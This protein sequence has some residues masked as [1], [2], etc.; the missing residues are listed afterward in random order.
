MAHRA[1]FIVGFALM[2]AGSAINLVTDSIFIAFRRAGVNA[3]VD[4]G[5]GGTIKL[6]LIPV[7]AGSGV[8]GL[9]I[10]SVG[11]FAAAAV[12]SVILIWSMLH[13][14]PRLRESVAVMRPLLRFSAANYLAGVFAL[15]PSLVV[16]L[17]VLARLGASDAAYYYVAY[18]LANL[19]F[20]A[21]Y[22][23]CQ[24]FLAEGG[25]EEEDLKVLTRPRRRILAALTVPACLVVIV[26]APALLELFGA[27][28]SSHGTGFLILMALAAIPVAALNWL[29]NILRLLRQLVS[30]AVCNGAYAVAVC[31]LAWVLAPRGL[32]F[33]GVAWL[34]GSLV[35]VAVAA[36]GVRIGPGMESRG[37]D[38]PHREGSRPTT[39]R[40]SR[41]GRRVGARRGNKPPSAM[42]RGRAA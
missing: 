21:G 8:Y 28:Y 22:A 40:R 12:A 17:I 2:G 33:L 29:V 34:A 23:V 32:S 26:G 37:H 11:G 39:H 14:R 38:D 10:A 24:S 13:V 1:L 16:P 3:L 7:A 27:S 25:H 36:I 35:A 41:S 4:G 9:Y 18:Q 20:A 19:V 31:G 30:V 15:S 6:L 5:I 42:R